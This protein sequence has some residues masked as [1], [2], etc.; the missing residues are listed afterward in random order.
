MSY[1]I[2]GLSQEIRQLFLLSACI[3]VPILAQ[4]CSLPALPDLGRVQIDRWAEITGD[5]RDVAAI[6]AAFNRAEEALHENNLDG[7]MAL[8]S[9]RYRHHGLSKD[10]LRTI[11]EEMMKDYDGL[12]STHIFSRV[13]AIASGKVPTAR[14]SCTGSFWGV[15]KATKQRDII[16]SW[17]FEIHDLVYEDGAWRIFGH[18]GGET[19]TVPFGRS[20]HPFF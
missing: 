12:A 18:D 13:K 8:Y 19:A 15:S 17:F 14:I 1:G 4:G 10:D 2:T 3:V 7:V 16:D 9:D 11:W 20:P 6:L 5:D